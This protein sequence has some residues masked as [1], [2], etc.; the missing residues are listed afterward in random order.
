VA[1]ALAALG[2]VVVG[3]SGPDGG[4]L[5]ACPFRAMTGLDCPGCGMTRGLRALVHGHPL[6]AL[7]HNVLLAALVP[8]TVWGW[9]G[10]AAFPVPRLP[11]L[12]NR[13]WAL[14]V[15]L[16]AAFAVVRNLPLP[17]CRWLGSS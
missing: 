9:L 12:S 10:W 7:G 13:A 4:V 5:P 17:G 11:R 16:L 1:L 8:L 3:L 6:A 15:G 14:V 2:C